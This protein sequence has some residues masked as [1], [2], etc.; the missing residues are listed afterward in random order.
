MIPQKL[1]NNSVQSVNH[2][3]QEI[4]LSSR[5]YKFFFIFYFIL[6]KIIGKSRKSW[7][8]NMHRGNKNGWDLHGYGCC[9]TVQ[10][11]RTVILISIFPK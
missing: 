11:V 7:I 3:I 1:E 2:L 8:F 10:Q 6:F 4:R 5:L 9:A